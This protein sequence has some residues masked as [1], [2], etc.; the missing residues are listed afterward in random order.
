MEKF[1]TDHKRHSKQTRKRGNF[2]DVMKNVYKKYR[3][4]IVL[5]GEKLDAFTLRSGKRQ[6]CHL[7]PLIFSVPLEISA[8]KIIQ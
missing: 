8:K 5:D 4:D 2:L 6:G 1:D 3:A 7:S